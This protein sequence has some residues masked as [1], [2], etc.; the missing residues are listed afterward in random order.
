[1]HEVFCSCSLSVKS[2][3]KFIYHFKK[4]TGKRS[5]DLVELASVFAGCYQYYENSASDDFDYLHSAV[6]CFDSETRVTAESI[7]TRWNSRQ[8]QFFGDIAARVQ[9]S[10]SCG[11]SQI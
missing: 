5:T 6:D 8:I 9:P 11:A 1:M 10:Q 3:F 7:G 2:K 4:F